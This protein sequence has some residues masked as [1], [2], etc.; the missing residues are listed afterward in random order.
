LICWREKRRR[1]NGR[2]KDGDDADEAAWGGEW[3]RSFGALPRTRETIDATL[4]WVGRRPRSAK[5]TKMRLAWRSRSSTGKYCCTAA[6]DFGPPASRRPLGG[7]LCHLD[8]AHALCH[9]S[10]VQTTYI[11]HGSERV[12]F[13]R[14]VVSSKVQT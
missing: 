8:S 7:V 1:P 4:A 14:S 11:S 9:I 6:I 10:L 3:R 13:V 12:H 5:L 2:A